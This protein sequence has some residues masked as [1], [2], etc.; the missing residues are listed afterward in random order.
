MAT[1]IAACAFACAFMSALM[2]GIA[3]IEKETVAFV[4]GLG[5]AAF[6]GAL[7]SLWVQALLS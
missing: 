5:I 1:F 3:L 2:L 7:V 6:C 4:A